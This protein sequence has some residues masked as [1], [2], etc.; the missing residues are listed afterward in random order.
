MSEV[1]INTCFDG[2]EI[3]LLMIQQALSLSS[4]GKIAVQLKNAKLSKK[5]SFILDFC[6]NNKNIEKLLKTNVIPEATNIYGIDILF[7][8][9]SINPHTYNILYLSN[10]FD[11]ILKHSSVYDMF[12]KFDEIWVADQD[13]ANILKKLGIQKNIFIAYPNVMV[14]GNNQQNIKNNIICNFPKY[15]M[16]DWEVFFRAYLQTKKFS[17]H[18]LTIIS[19]IFVGEKTKYDYFVDIIKKN[20]NGIQN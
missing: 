7:H 18:S 5:D 6:K 14:D 13:V 1:I 12:S 17:N 10:L 9:V 3:S 4:D 16:P 8:T 2:S 19:D 15:A 11:N 20:K